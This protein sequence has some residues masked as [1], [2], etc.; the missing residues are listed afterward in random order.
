MPFSGHGPISKT[1]CCAIAALCVAM[2]LVAVRA[3]A[4][5]SAPVLAWHFDEADGDGA[6]EQM[7]HADGVVSGVYLHVPGVSGGA[8]RLDGET[9]GVSVKAGTVPDLGAAFTV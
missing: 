4:Q 2:L 1:G 8:L 5:N 3:V 9:S 6:A 7:R